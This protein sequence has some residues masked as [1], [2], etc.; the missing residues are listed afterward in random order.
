MNPIIGDDLN[1]QV[2]SS[3]EN[4]PLGH[5]YVGLKDSL[6]EELVQIRLVSVVLSYIGYV[7]DV[8]TSYDKQQSTA[9]YQQSEENSKTQ[10]QLIRHTVSSDPS[11]SY[12]TEICILIKM[13]Y[14]TMLPFPYK[15]KLQR[16][17]I[18]CGYFPSDEISKWQSGNCEYLAGL[19]IFDEDKNITPGFV[20]NVSKASLL[21]ALKK[22]EHNNLLWKSEICSQDFCKN[23]LVEFH[24]LNINLIPNA[25]YVF[26]LRRLE[27]EGVLLHAP[28]LDMQDNYTRTQ[29][30]KNCV[31][32]QGFNY[33]S[34]ANRNSIENP[35]TLSYRLSFTV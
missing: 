2:N 21:E 26:W 30:K 22:E 25:K 12:G 32:S 1:K 24:N 14:Q 27:K 19:Q 35:Y 6:P 34:G 18:L 11:P 29:F 10:L 3:R 28:F 17:E 4:D 7:E 15:Y 23:Q 13:P 8:L 9:H 33:Y 31:I 16:V 5:L 20:W